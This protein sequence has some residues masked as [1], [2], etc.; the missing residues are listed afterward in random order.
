MENKNYKI[1]GALIII[2]FLGYMLY[3]IIKQNTLDRKYNKLELQQSEIIKTRDSLIIV[4]RI[5]DSLNKIDGTD[6][7]K[8]KQNSIKA[9]SIVNNAS[10]SE[11]Q[12]LLYKSLYK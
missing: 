10:I 11:L 5:I 12:K 7:D 6:V 3:S 1:G 2:A 4:N 8:I 9:D